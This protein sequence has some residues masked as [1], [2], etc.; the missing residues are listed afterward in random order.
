MKASMAAMSASATMRRQGISPAPMTAPAGNAPRPIARRHAARTRPP[1]RSAGLC[2]A[3]QRSVVGTTNGDR[4]FHQK[5]GYGRVTAVEGNKL[6][7][8][9]DKAG[10]KR[11]ID[12]FVT[13]A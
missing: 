3:D 2:G 12:N 1:H 5:F 11:V 10:T 13:R 8:D 7:V 6:T 9:F 4:V